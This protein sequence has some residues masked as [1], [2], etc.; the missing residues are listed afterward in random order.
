[1]SLSVNESNDQAAAPNLESRANGPNGPVAVGDRVR[2]RDA[3]SYLLGRV[4]GISQP[5]DGEGMIYDVVY[6]TGTD[7][8]QCL[9][10]ESELS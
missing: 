7:R 10:H 3:K 8:H 6:W 1:M 2:L 9:M 4:V 5:D